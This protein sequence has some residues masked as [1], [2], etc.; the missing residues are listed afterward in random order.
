MSLLSSVVGFVGCDGGDRYSVMCSRS[1]FCK[2]VSGLGAIERIV[3]A[4]N[5]A[6]FVAF[7]V[8]REE[9]EGAGR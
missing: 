3:S 4:W 6:S 9:V 2:T 1:G 5:V 8:M 7:G